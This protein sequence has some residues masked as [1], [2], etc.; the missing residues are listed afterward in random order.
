MK[1]KR[2]KLGRPLICYPDVFGTKVTCDETSETSSTPQF[3]DRFV[4]EGRT[5]SLEKIR[6][7]DLGSSSLN[8]NDKIS[9]TW[10]EWGYSP[11][12]PAKRFHHIQVKRRE[13]V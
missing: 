3:K 10:M 5:T 1:V 11:R 7:E 8:A 9:R 2:R 12:Q 6:A 4:F 13:R